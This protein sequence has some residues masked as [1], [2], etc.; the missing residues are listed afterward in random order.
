[1]KNKQKKRIAK[2]IICICSALAA[3]TTGT[4]FFAVPFGWGMVLCLWLNGCLPTWSMVS[5]M[6]MAGILG[7][8][9]GFGMGHIVKE[10]VEDDL[11]TPTKRGVDT[12]Q[13]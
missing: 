9:V 4:L 11:H 3:W 7:I 12:T 1:M 5:I 10:L 2:I 6:C 8:L 13:S